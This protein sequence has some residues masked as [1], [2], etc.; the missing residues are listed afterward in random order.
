MDEGNASGYVEPT[1]EGTSSTGRYCREFPHEITIGGAS[2]QRYVTACR[3]PDG[4]WEAI[5]TGQ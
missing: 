3:Q 5:S 1:R 2:E 4:C